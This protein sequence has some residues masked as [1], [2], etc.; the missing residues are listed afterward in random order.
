MANKYEY[1]CREK[2]ETLAEQARRLGVTVATLKRQLKAKRDEEAARRA[3]WAL[4]EKMP[5]GIPVPATRDEQPEREHDRLQD[6]GCRGHRRT[7]PQA[8]AGRLPTAGGA[9]K[10][11]LMP[12]AHLGYGVAHR[13]R[14]GHEGCAQPRSGRRG[15]WLP[16]EHVDFRDRACDHQQRLH[17]L[18]KCLEEQ[19]LLR[20]GR[21]ERRPS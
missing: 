13:G 21:G 6:L 12:D 17:R 7:I 15:H 2:N 5:A 19:H 10:A 14:R 20:R 16:H 8:D 4:A 3:L 9:V 18:P 11:A 1:H